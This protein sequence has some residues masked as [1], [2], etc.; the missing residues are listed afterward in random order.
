M[1]IRFEQPAWLWLLVLAAPAVALGV[2]WLVGMSPVRRWTAVAARL[3][4]IGLVT[5]M[6]AGASAVRRTERLAVIAVVD[7]SGS[8]QRL[9]QFGRREDGRPVLASEAAREFLVRASRGRGPDDLL[10]VVVFDGAAAAV[11]T[12]TRADVLGEEGRTLEVTMREGTNIA[13]TLRLAAAMFPPDATRRIVLMSDGNE[14]AGRAVD[15]AREQASGGS[16]GRAAWRGVTG[17]TPIDVVPIEYRLER[18]VLVETV[19]APPR[20]SPGATVS[21]RVVLLATAPTEGT[22]RLLREGEAVDLNGAEEG[23]GRR[24]ALRAGRNVEVIPVR[25]GESRVNRF[26]AIFEPDA[27]SAAG[28]GVGGAA[29]DTIESNN[30]GEAFTISPGTGSVLVIDGVSR[31]D[32]EGRGAIL[33]RTLEEAGLR[34]HAVPPEGAPGDLLSMEAY[35]LVILQNVPADALARSTQEMLAAYVTDAGGGLVMVGGPASFG[36][37]GWKGSALEPI[38]PVRLDLP[39]KMIVPSAATVLVLDRSGSMSRSVMGSGRTQQDVANEGAAVAVLTMDRTDLVSVIQF[40]NEVAVLRPLGPNRDPDGLAAVIR[41]IFPNGGTNIPP[42]LEAA[43]EQLR[44]A[45]AAVR[46]VILLT[47]GISQNRERLPGVAERMAADGIRLSTIAVGDEADAPMLARIAEIG[48][49]TFYRVTDPDT[50]PRIFVKAVRVMRSPMIRETPFEPVVVAA[51]PALEGVAEVGQAL[52]A[53]G[54]LALTQPLA[55]AT[56]TLAAVAPTGEPVLAHWSA[57]VGQV[58]AFT[59]DAHDQWAAGWLSW[60]GYRRMWT[61]L[62]RQVSRAASDRRAELTTQI[63]GDR[64]LLR[65]EVMDEGGRPAELLSAP[66]KVFGPEGRVVETRLT[67]TGP[68][69]Y[70]GSVAA[71]ATGTYVAMVLPRTHAEGAVAAGAARRPVAPIVGGATRSSGAEFRALRS[72][73]ELLRELARLTGGRVLNMGDPEGANL[74]DRSTVRPTEARVPL[75]RSLLVWAVVV[76]LLDVGTRRVAWDRFLSR[77]FGADLRREAAEALR[78]RGVAAAR[79]VERLRGR[80]VKRRG[81]EGLALNEEDARRIIREQAERRRAEREARRAA[82]APAAAK[83]EAGGGAAT[84]DLLA[85]KRR[86]RERFGDAGGD[87]GEASQ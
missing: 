51:S 25:L 32:P 13:E 4:L 8:V 15:A 9:A 66:A 53:L 3:A 75:W 22:L 52:P 71:E 12:P 63:E 59:S 48:Q 70:E 74:F 68:G 46:H 18:E 69:V 30:R 33:G 85:A 37:G 31:G 34:V 7:V 41:G 14:T 38:L 44:G 57:G 28:G 24:V 86:A 61:Q 45:N 19:D 62:A 39:E 50:L 83:E 54:G 67:Q 10:G 2:R 65:L 29:G 76:L 77:S 6:L 16:A 58:A 60:P 80:P 82:G 79:T 11:V 87:E 56:V 55:D 43:H 72:N 49:G 20:A 21:V 42:A 26:E 36:A 40:D 84:S 1:T 73:A 17:G 47:D 27:S 64:L 23:T 78:D 5:G 81:P 35:D